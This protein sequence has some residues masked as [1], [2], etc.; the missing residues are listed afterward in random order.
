MGGEKLHKVLARHGKGSRREIER[1]IADGRVT[2]DGF[3]AQTGLRVDGS[4]TVHLDGKR[5]RLSAAKQDQATRVLIYNKP[6][7]QLCTRRDP[8]G[9][10]TIFESLPSISE[11]RWITVG[12]LDLNTT[13]LLLVTNDGELAERLMHPR[14]QIEREYACRVLGEATSL[15]LKKLSN[16]VLL[17][18]QLC[19]F[20]S[21]LDKG[22]RGANHWY[23]VTL[24]EGRNR[25]VRRLWE[26]VGLRVSRL[27]R[28]R[29][30]PI[31]LPKDLR[32][33]SWI[34]LNHENVGKL[35]SGAD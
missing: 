1:W 27:L 15:K 7:G 28:I 3:V 8:Q 25:E 12:R 19:R 26:K 16:G 24:M 33:G 30:G 20:S 21:I 32:V 18:G 17:D 31:K 34:E 29:F 9:R 13:G 10:P 23:H 6:E 22:G 14:Y 2:V 11:G 4:E 35:Y 5:I